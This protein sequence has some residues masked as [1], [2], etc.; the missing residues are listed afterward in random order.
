GDF[1]TLTD[2]NGELLR[3]VLSLAESPDGTTLYGVTNV[4]DKPF[5]RELITID[6]VSGETQSI[7]SLGMHMADLA[8]VPLPTGGPKVTDVF[9]RGAAWAAPFLNAI[10]TAGLRGPHARAK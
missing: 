6:P 1:V 2:K 8:S 10:A 5:L 3:G 4:R 7:G 9:V